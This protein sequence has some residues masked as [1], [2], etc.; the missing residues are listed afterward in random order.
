MDWQFWSAIAAVVAIVLSQLP[1]IRLWFLPKKLEVEVHSRIQVTHQVGNPNVGMF[2]SIRNTGGRELRIRSLQITMTRESF[3]PIVLHA[4]NYFESPSSQASTLFVP[5]SLKPSDTWAHGT[6][7]LNLFDR[8]TEKLYRESESK[9][10]TDIK[11]KLQTRPEGSKSMVEAEPE[12]VL[13]FIQLFNKLFI[14]QPA[15]YVAELIVVA[16]PGSAS[17]SKKYRFTIFESDS[18]E[19]SSYKEDYKF[20]GG[21]TFNTEKHSGVFVPLTPHLG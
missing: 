8:S 14:W 21:L 10:S 3:S 4:Q 7:F 13:P 20:G 9:L 11:N 19:L 1:P 12:F 6:N 17:F 2:V 15:E 5:F 16:E 18:H